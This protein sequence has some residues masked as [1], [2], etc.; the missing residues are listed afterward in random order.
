MRFIQRLIFPIVILLIHACVTGQKIG[1]L[2][3]NKLD[4]YIEEARQ[5][6]NVPGIAIAIVKNDSVVFKS[7]YGVRE[8]GKPERVDEN[9]IF[10]IASI[11]K[12]FTSAALAILDDENKINWDD[13]VRKHLP[14]FTLYDPYVNNEIRIRDLLCHR[15]G[16]KTFSGD[17]VWFDI[18]GDR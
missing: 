3:L 13:P 15:S 14:D 8:Y 9:T 7:G 5:A 2:D 10:S 16:L 6:W 17:L 11:T 4:T 18:N 1:E 12:T